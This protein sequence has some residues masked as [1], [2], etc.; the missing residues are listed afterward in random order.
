[1]Y[2]NID[3]NI[4]L[5]V[6]PSNQEWSEEI[7]NN[8]RFLLCIII[9]N[10]KYYHLLYDIPE[11]DI[12]D[13][14]SQLDKNKLIDLSKKI[15]ELS[16]KDNYHILSFINSCE[17]DNN[18]YFIIS[19]LKGSTNPF[20]GEWTESIK[21]IVKHS[22]IDILNNNLDLQLKIIGEKSDNKNYEE[23]L[24]NS[25]ISIIYRLNSL[26]VDIQKTAYSQS[27]YLDKLVHLI[28]KKKFYNSRKFKYDYEKI[29]KAPSEI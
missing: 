18:D 17:E 8:T 22:L 4:K 2:H 16:P 11:Y 25:L 15:T 26:I 19:W 24:L 3:E 12:D 6:A 1:M 27:I 21:S 14:V 5:L 13:Y 20:S 7:L 28:K 29:I 10:N 23:L 9:F